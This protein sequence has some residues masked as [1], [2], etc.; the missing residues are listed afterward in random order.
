MKST[1]QL[2][3][4]LI[5]GGVLLASACSPVG[6]PS[7]NSEADQSMSTS[8]QATKQ[9]AREDLIT[10][11]T[12]GNIQMPAPGLIIH[13]LSSIQETTL[14][15]DG[16][17]F[18]DEVASAAM[19]REPL[20]DDDLDKFENTVM[21]PKVAVLQKANLHLMSAKE[22]ANMVA[23]I[24]KTPDPAKA[25]VEREGAVIGAMTWNGA[26]AG[27]LK[28]V[29][30]QMVHIR[31]V[32]SAAAWCRTATQ[33]TNVWPVNVQAEAMKSLPDRMLKELRITRAK[34]DKES[35]AAVVYA[36]TTQQTIESC[37]NL[38]AKIAADLGPIAYADQ[39]AL[40]M[41]V[42]QRLIAFTP[43]ELEAMADRRLPRSVLYDGTT[44]AKQAFNT[45]DGRFENAGSG[46]T[47]ARGNVV[48]LDGAHVYGRAITVSLASAATGTM[49]QAITGNQSLAA[50][51]VERA[52]DAMQVGQP[53]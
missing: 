6:G 47:W 12:S 4:A 23:A 44:A 38:I 5:L 32:L 9:W 31:M 53:K 8:H 51:A 52:K 17:S 33:S 3:L 42:Y 49:R 50:N 29:D 45:D 26:R 15:P 48:Y 14:P 24:A 25:W 40:Q 36:N 34:L 37:A 27:D 7:A 30:A 2:S 39:S 18:S 22:F 10:K 19:A 46:W 43:A 13:A 28:A 1:K 11:S 16:V 35:R 20:T 41:A 21:F